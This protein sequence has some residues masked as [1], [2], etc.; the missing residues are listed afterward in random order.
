MKIELANIR[1]ERD[2]LADDLKVAI[3]RITELTAR[4]GGELV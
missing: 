2:E 1:R 4:I 3:N